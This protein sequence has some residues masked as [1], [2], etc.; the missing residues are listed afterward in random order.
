MFGRLPKASKQCVP[1]RLENAGT[2]PVEVGATKTSCDCFTVELAST[3]I[4]PGASVEGTARVDFTT[5]PNFSGNLALDATGQSSRGEIAFVVR[6][7][8][9]V[10]EQRAGGER[11]PA[12]VR[13]VSVRGG[14]DRMVLVG[15][16][17]RSRRREP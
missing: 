7:A 12:L 13:H 17:L 8:V 4:P 1:F 11:F 2:T 14:S 10:E 6:A 16:K 3:T 15:A 9:T 5:H